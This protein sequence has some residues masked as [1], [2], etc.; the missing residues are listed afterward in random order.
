[1]SA[2]QPRPRVQ[3]DPDAV[4]DATGHSVPLLEGDGSR[5]HE[6]VS[7]DELRARATSYAASSA[8]PDLTGVRTLVQFAGFPRSG[9]SVVGSLIDAHPDAAV[10]HELDLM[11]LIGSGLTREELFALVCASSAEFERHGRSWNGFSYQV[12][13][14]YGGTASRPM[15]VGDKKAD[16]AVRR[17]R[18]DPALVGS[19]A[20]ALDGVRA[21]WVV[22]VRNPFD[23]VATMSLRKG[24]AYDRIRIRSQG[25]DD[26]R[27][28]LERARGERVPAEVLPEMVAD[29]AGLCDGVARLK[30]SVADE[31]WLV[32]R[33]EDLVADPSA[34][35]DRLFAFLG[36][37][38]EPGLRH[39]L[40]GAVSTDV[41]RSRH[42]I[43]W[44]GTTRA[45]VERLVAQHDFLAGCSFD[46]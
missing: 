14:G 17:V 30:R 29:Y 43:A 6:R 22:V 36:L 24:R 12:P 1:M 23:N 21:A 27:R 35:L 16:W 4:P 5:R 7:I 18:E 34:S 3:S 20:A 46:D 10:A 40:A 25:P 41:N 44:P 13:G 32:L 19:L 42:Q 37:P 39:R 11:G 2:D 26:F 33:H 31:D 38:L 28:R 8:A 45:Q 15:V 9:H